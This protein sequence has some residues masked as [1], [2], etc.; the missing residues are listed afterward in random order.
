MAAK[1]KP[2]WNTCGVP[3]IDAFLAAAIVAFW[4]SELE[5]WEKSVR[6]W[7]KRI[8]KTKNPKLIAEAKK[9]LERAQRNL[10]IV[11]IKEQEAKEKLS[12]L[13]KEL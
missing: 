7:K 13:L 9:S 8:T 3:E 6:E 2:V 4:F 12:I 11:K 10:A 5:E 1:K